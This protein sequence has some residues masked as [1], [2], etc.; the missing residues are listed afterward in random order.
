[1][2]KAKVALKAYGYVRVSVDEEDGNNASI[3]S[4]KQ[5]IETYAAREGYELVWVFE[6]PGV[7]GRKL[8]RKQFDRMIELATGPER[9]VHVVIVYNLNRFARRLL[10]QVMAE[11]KLQTA[12]VQLVS[13]TEEFGNGP[14]GQMMRNMIAVM[15]EKYAH[16]ASLFTRR[17]RRT[18]ARKGYWNGGQ[19]PYG[20]E[21]KPVVRDGD[22]ERKKL[23]IVEEEASVVRKIFELARHGVVG[24]PMG[25]RSIAEWLNNHGYR[26]RGRPFFHSAVDG[27]L[28]RPHYRGSYF[29]RTA[30]DEGK[31]PEPEDW[32]WVECPRIIEGE[33]AEEVAVIRAKAAPAKTPPRITN[34][35]TLLTGIAKC[36]MP[37]CG[38]GLTVITGKSG[39]YSYYS[40]GAKATGAA[41][42]CSCKNIPED[43]LDDIVLG[44]LT[45]RL[46]QP[47]R[48]RE[49]LAYVLEESSEADER[50]SK[51]VQ[52]VRSERTRVETAIGKLLELAE[53]GL[54]SPRDPI[55]A[56]R[57][58]DQRARQAALTS[59]IESLQRQ[60]QRGPKRLTPEA[61]DRFGAALKEKLSG[62]DPVLRKAYV[63]LLV[64]WVGLSNDEIT[65]SGSQLAME[66]ALVKGDRAATG[67]VP[68]FDRGWCPG[69]DSNLHALAS[70]ST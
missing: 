36:D 51:E 45:Q 11:H 25:T 64:S 65:I 61:V 33:Q 16:D 40:C 69:E 66:H 32:I 28:K 38:R 43:Q 5:A 59:T 35:P 42:R 20:Y 23:F 47:A 50:R 8:A 30:D 58:A 53:E 52:Q 31:V 17:D 18:N 21:A 63:R 1:M 3:E 12:G 55:F 62:N 6:E 13:I 9:P 15:N 24:Q 37:G 34:G 10:T 60:L 2:V 48:L 70:A 41:A 22:K 4:Q 56:K 57:M 27:I 49:L 39:Q 7:S 44:E 19:V 26:L 14:N 46:L 68:S 67:V 54:M 29:D